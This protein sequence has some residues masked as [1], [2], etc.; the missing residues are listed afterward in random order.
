MILFTDRAEYIRCFRTTT[1]GFDNIGVIHK[2]NEDMDWVIGF[3]DKNW[4][5]YETSL[6]GSEK[7][8]IIGLLDKLNGIGYR[9]PDNMQARWV[10]IIGLIGAAI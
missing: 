3:A 6:D 8:Q 9:N 2:Q 4:E 7:R 10:E 1:D 5:H